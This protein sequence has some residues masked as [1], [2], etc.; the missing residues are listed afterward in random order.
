MTRVK[1]GTIKVK[2]RERLLRHAKGFTWGRK[3]KAR[4]AKEALFHAW[5]YQYRDRRRKKREFRR[6]WQIRINAALKTHGLSYSRFTHLLKERGVTLD[7]KI[8]SKL[9]ET[10]P[11]VFTKIVEKVKT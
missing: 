4:L 10:H 9:A 5:T 3:S 11:D 7:R 2:K 8:L 6:L 1:R